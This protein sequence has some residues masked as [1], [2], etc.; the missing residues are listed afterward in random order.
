ML[1]KVHALR[2]KPDQKIIDEITRYCQQKSISSGVV[3]G[4]IGSVKSIRLGTPP[5]TKFGW[6]YQDHTGPFS[7]ASGQGT[8]ALLD[9]KLIVHIHVVIS[10]PEVTLSGHIF[11]A[12]T[13]ST[14][15][16][17]IGEL[18][19]QLYRDHDPDVS[20]GQLRTT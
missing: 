10:R 18:D 5:G 6:E 14:T 2:V 15:E 1:K 3:I 19:Y 17:I 11:E 7:L 4:I 13:Y 12:E 20:I 8:I 16:I 9:D